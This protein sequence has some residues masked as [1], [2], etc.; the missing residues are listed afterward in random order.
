MTMCL[1]IISLAVAVLID[2]LLEAAKMPPAVG[3]W[4]T[5]VW[6]EATVFCLGRYLRSSRNTFPRKLPT[7]FSLFPPLV[8]EDIR[9]L[10]QKSI[11]LFSCLPTAHKMSDLG[12]QLAVMSQGS[13]ITRPAGC[14]FLHLGQPCSSFVFIY[15][16]VTFPSCGKCNKSSFVFFKK[17][18][19]T[20]VGKWV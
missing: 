12:K 6:T 3:G 14:L 11:I 20:S 19:K 7:V 15:V 2:W 1:M 13:V 16:F 17:G 8:N 9:I 18:S 10:E 4:H 5:T